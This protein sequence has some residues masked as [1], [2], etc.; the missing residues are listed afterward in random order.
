MCHTRLQFAHVRSPDASTVEPWKLQFGH[1]AV[2]APMITG[3][4]SELSALNGGDG[5]FMQHAVAA[6]GVAAVDR[7]DTVKIRQL[8]AR[9]TQQTRKRRD[10]PLADFGLDADFHAAGCHQ[11]MPP[12][13]AEA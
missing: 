9:F 7:F 4:R 2:M 13:M 5:G 10:V 3:M 11:Q 12:A 6:H 1:C 8:A